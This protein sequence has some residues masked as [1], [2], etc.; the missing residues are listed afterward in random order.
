MAT[1]GRKAYSQALTTILSTELNSLANGSNSAASTAVDNSSNLDLYADFLLT[2]TFG[3]APSAG[4]TCDLYVMPSLDGT[5]YADGG[6][7]VIPAKNLYVGSFYVRNVTTAQVMA[8]NNILIPQYFK[9]VIV[10]NTG[11]T[12]AASGNTL[13]Y[14]TFSLQSV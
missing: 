11:Q 7:S 14:R 2:V 6:S 13:K 12:M 10:N 4:T 9:L 5:T 3:T 8:L 1:I